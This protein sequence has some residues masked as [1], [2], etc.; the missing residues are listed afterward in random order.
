MSQA[1][2]V[3]EISNEAQRCV[4]GEGP[5]WD[6]KSQ[7]LYYVDIVT[8]SIYRYNIKNGEIYKAKIKDNDEP[9]GFMI[10]VDGTTDELVVG[11]GREVVVI[12]WDGKSALATVVRVLGE[13]DN[14]ITANRINDGKCDPKGRL[15]FGTM[16]DNENSDLKANPTGSFYRF[17][18]AEV[19]TT[20]LKSLVGISNGLTWNETLGKFYYIDSVVRDVKVFDYDSSN[21]NISKLLN[22]NIFYNS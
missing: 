3:R 17:K 15:Y 9:I 19:P 18:N 1:I 10:P 12:R 2:T 16:G 13:V 7:S 20:K 5:H 6:I 21:G 11:A 14:F 22:A 4:L 8:P